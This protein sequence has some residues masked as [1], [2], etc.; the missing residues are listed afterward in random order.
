MILKAAEEKPPLL[1]SLFMLDRTIAPAFK[2]PQVSSLKEAT[3][4]KLDNGSNYH[5][6]EAGTQP[7]VRI[8]IFFKNGSWY[9]PQNGVSFL[10]AKMLGEGTSKYS[11]STIQEMIASYG[12]FIEFNCGIER[13]SITIYT[14]TKFAEKLIPLVKELLT[15][16]IFP[17]KEFENLQK[18]TVQ[19]I[20]VNSNKTSYLAANHFK[21][22]LFGEKHPYGKVLTEEA[23]LSVKS[24]QIKEYYSTTFKSD[25]CDIIVSGQGAEKLQDIFNKEFKVIGKT[26]SIDTPKNIPTQKSTQKQ[27]LI[28]KEDSVQSSIRMGLELPLITHPDYF[29]LFI[30][31]EVLGGYFGSRLMQNI[32]E[33][34][35][36]TYGISASYVTLLNASYLGI[37]T[38]VNKE[39]TE[40]TIREVYKEINRLKNE[41]IGED[42]LT[43]V[44]NYL[45]GAFINSITTP[46]CLADKF[47][48]IYFNG[49]SYDFY[50]SYLT[51]IKDITSDE[52]LE[53][54]NKY[55]HES[56][57]I[58]VVAGGR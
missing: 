12:A 39:N 9:E 57:I 31:I 28:N 56:E 42:E 2:Q 25:V 29:N 58:E 18:L 41:P 5:F 52:I 37:A 34:K 46:F 23:V 49:L 4:I 1:N 10:T 19:N 15:D 53:I 43:T 24:E 40:N 21:Q 35:G 36:Y 3:S 20:K 47:K 16:S 45:L 14:L 50:K 6:I 33:D 11:A 51:R 54:G 7:V 32:R 30:L 44:K 26:S 8:E 13:T 17:Q 55:L 22:S 27:H 48:S 38:D